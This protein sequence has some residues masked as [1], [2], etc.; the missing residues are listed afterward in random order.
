MDLRVEDGKIVFAKY[1][2]DGQIAASEAE[3]DEIIKDCRSRG[4]EPVVVAADQPTPEQV[5]LAASVSISTRSR[6][7]R[8]LA[9]GAAPVTLED[10]EERVKKLEKK[11]VFA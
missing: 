1:L 5:A 4:R 11:V 6:A 9:S 8:V 7:L 2:V 10:L 3:R